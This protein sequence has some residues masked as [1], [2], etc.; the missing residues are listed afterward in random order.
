MDMQ[1][2]IRLHYLTASK[3]LLL[4][5]IFGC[6]NVQTRK[7]VDSINVISEKD[8]NSFVSSD[9]LFPKITFDTTFINLDTMQEGEIKIIEYCFKNTGSAP[10]II[11][12]IIPSCGCSTPSYKNIPILPG[13]QSKIK[14]VFNSE[15]K[16]G[17]QNLNLVV[18]TNT[19]EK[20]CQLKFYAFIKPK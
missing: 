7:K 6:N 15:N 1:K 16:I 4:I 8:S 13:E 11:K 20:Y 19:Y 5:L 14:L 10:L 17:D 3:F 2:V 18:K 9:S 12:D